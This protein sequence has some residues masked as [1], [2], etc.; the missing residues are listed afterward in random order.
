MA[1]RWCLIAHPDLAVATPVAEE[2]FVGYYEPRG[3]T[4]TSGWTV[5]PHTPADAWPP[6][7]DAPLK[8]EDEQEKPAPKKAA[9]KDKE[10]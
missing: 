2:A 3:W 1:M 8:A 10:S 7:E 9:A 4:R 5:D 6:H